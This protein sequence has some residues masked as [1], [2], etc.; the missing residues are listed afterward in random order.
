MIVGLFAQLDQPWLSSGLHPRGSID[1]VSKQ[2]ISGT[3]QTHNSSGHTARVE[4]PSEIKKKIVGWLLWL[5]SK[6]G[7]L[8][9]IKFKKKK[10]KFRFTKVILAGVVFLAEY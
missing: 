7:E 9:E 6:I 3:R 8:V 10:A 2:A 4:A 1:G 5:S